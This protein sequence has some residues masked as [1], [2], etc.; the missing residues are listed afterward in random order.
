[1]SSRLIATQVPTVPS[2]TSTEPLIEPREVDS[3]GDAADIVLDTLSG[4][5][6][7]VLAA[8]PL[9]VIGLVI[10]IV[11]LFVAR[12]VGIW[13]E[14]GL[15]RTR[16]DRVVV[17]LTGRLA[18]FLTAVLFALLALAVAGVKVGAALAALGIVGLALAFAMQNILENFVSGIILMIRKPF[19]AGD[20][21]RTSDYEGTVEEIDLRV[22]R[23]STYDGEVVLI[24]NSDVFRSPLHNRTHRGRRRST[25]HIAVDYR[26][27]HDSARRIIRESI[28]DVEGVLREPP[29]EVL[30]TELG[31]SGV[32]FEMRYWTLPDNRT[33]RR[34]QD[35]VLGAAKSA[36]E[37]AGMTIPWPIRTLSFDTA[38]PVVD[39]SDRD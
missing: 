30:L 37:G 7:G 5:A 3:I 1:M 28:E 25:F 17:S 2:P 24:P 20:Q 26:D 10:F 33:V 39:G 15:E 19:R 4:I 23:I 18:Q 8:L 38:V 21:I 36:V 34:V 6:R 31:D 14:R 27:D 16:A 11:G 32:V 35:R 9:V 29:P 13:S 12:A 22:T